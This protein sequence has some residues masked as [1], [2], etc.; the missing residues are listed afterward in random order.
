MLA[1]VIGRQ[2]VAVN[3]SVASPASFAIPKIEQL[4]LAIGGN[5]NVGWLK[6]SMHHPE[7]MRDRDCTTECAKEHQALRKS[8]GFV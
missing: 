4:G 1:G 3:P 7:A 5:E 2:P 6:V 8:S